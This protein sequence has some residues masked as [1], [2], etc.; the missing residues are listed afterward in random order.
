MSARCCG[1]DTANLSML[2]GSPRCKIEPDRIRAGAAWQSLNGDLWR[3]EIAR[4]NEIIKNLPVLMKALFC[5]LVC[6]CVA[7][8][9]MSGQ[10]TKKVTRFH[11]GSRAN[12]VLQFSS[13]DY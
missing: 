2:H 4:R 9:A 5:A 13:W 11:D 1:F 8:C 3:G 10:A 12:V 7:G 6:L